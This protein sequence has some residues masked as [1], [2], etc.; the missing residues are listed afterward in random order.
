MGNKT[1]LGGHTVLTGGKGFTPLAELPI[2]IRNKKRKSKLTE[3]QV[4][5]KERSDKVAKRLHIDQR[6]KKQRRADKKREAGS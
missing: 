1:Y 3:N 4:A 2:R 5:A 6:T